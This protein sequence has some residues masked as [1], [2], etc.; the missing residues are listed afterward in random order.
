MDHNCSRFCCILH[1][2]KSVRMRSFSSLYFSAF[3]L[4]AD[5]KNPEYGHFLHSLN[6]VDTNHLD[7]NN[8]F[9]IL[10]TLILR[11]R[12]LVWEEIFQ[13]SVAKMSVL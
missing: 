1:C 5:Q 7:I 10:A 3:G 8:F 9:M 4:N 13:K 6:N 2:V 11:Y 12:K